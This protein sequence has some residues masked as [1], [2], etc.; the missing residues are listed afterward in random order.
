M[1]EGSRVRGLDSIGVRH[2]LPRM[3]TRVVP[4]PLPMAAL[5][6]T[7]LDRVD[8]SDAFRIELPASAPR[9]IDALAHA[10]FSSVPRWIGTLLSMRDAVVGPLGLKTAEAGPHAIPER[11]E[12]GDAVALFRVHQRS[13]TEIVFGED[14]S[15]LDFRVS[16][17]L[18]D[19]ALV[20]TTV[21]AFRSWLGRGY[22]LPVRPVHARIAPAMLRAACASFET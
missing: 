5:V 6:A 19:D 11:F 15:H 14:D 10:T 21:V 1:R 7:S 17:L 3:L 8:Y 18:D 22:F 9:S 4:V 16:L 13:E 2:H 20:M 12:V